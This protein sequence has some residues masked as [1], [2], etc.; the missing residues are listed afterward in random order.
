VG[1]DANRPVFGTWFGLV[2]KDLGWGATLPAPHAVTLPVRTLIQTLVAR[3]MSMMTETITGQVLHRRVHPETI[4]MQV[5]HSIRP[6]VGILILLRMRNPTPTSPRQN[7]WKWRGKSW[8]ISKQCPML[9]HTF[10]CLREN[11]LMIQ[12]NVQYQH[13]I[14]SL[15]G[16]HVTDKGKEK[17]DEKMKELVFIGGVE[18]VDLDDCDV[19]ERKVQCDS[20]NSDDDESPN[21][22]GVG[23]R[24]G[25]GSCSQTMDSNDE[26]TSRSVA[27]EV[28]E[29]SGP[30]TTPTTSIDDALF[31]AAG[32]AFHLD[33][34]IV[35]QEASWFQL[36]VE[37]R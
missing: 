6:A 12:L 37:K 30:H 23:V 21:A 35:K 8:T 13:R 11:H 28:G 27:L 26:S 18:L 31:N 19:T 7:R 15:A 14:L 33:A 25:L 2:H 20:T 22:D 16:E 34:V 24:D 3:E 5:R 9:R 4:L 17:V 36:W 29:H 32:K 1:K 10:L